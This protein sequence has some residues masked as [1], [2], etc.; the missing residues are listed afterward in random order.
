VAV[1]SPAKEKISRQHWNL[2][3]SAVD[4]TASPLVFGDSVRSSQMPQAGEACRA[5]N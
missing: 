1:M 5:A 2:P 4:G 3:R